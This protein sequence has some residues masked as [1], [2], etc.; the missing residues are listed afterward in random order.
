MADLMATWNEVADPLDLFGGQ[1]SRMAADIQSQLAEMGLTLERDFYNQ[2]R[3]DEAPVREARNA[4]LAALQGLQDGSYQ[5]PED[6][7]L[8]LQER[9]ALTDINK[10]AAAQGKSL[11]GGT[12]EAQ[13]DALG[14]LRSNSTQKQLSRLLNLSGYQTNDLLGSNSLIAR[15]TDSQANQMQ[16]LNA[17]NQ[18]YDIGQS[19]AVLNVMGQGSR[20]A[21]SVIPQS[22][23][24]PQPG[25]MLP[26][27]N[28]NPQAFAG[29]A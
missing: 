29:Y 22:G 8:A 9:N 13:Q 21:G 6:P 10:M 18:S 3:E 19:N 24:Q 27:Q 12:F 28:Y 1:A 25:R 5:L 4:A 16:N 11:A 15:N 2:L 26:A 14:A 17:I 20:F 7:A 23:N